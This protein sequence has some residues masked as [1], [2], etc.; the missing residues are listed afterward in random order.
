MTGK[1]QAFAILL[2]APLSSAIYSYSAVKASSSMSGQTA[3]TSYTPANDTSQVS[4]SLTGRFVD[5]VINATDKYLNINNLTV[6]VAAVCD[7]YNLLNW[8]DTDDPLDTCDKRRIF[9]N[10]GTSLKSPFQDSGVICRITVGVATNF[11]TSSKARRLDRI[12]G[13]NSYITKHS[14]C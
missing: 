2:T 6:T 10:K 1:L 5:D 4:L 3:L 12:L 9:K 11:R 8:N 7:I 13:L 14:I